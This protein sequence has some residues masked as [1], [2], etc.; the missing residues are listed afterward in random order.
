MLKFIKGLAMKIIIL[1]IA[2]ISSIF[3]SP[4]AEFDRQ[5]YEVGEKIFEKKCNSCHEKYMNIQLLMKNFLYEDNKLLNLK[6]PTGNELSF[7]LKNQIGSKD[8][9]EF[10]I[11]E[12]IDFVTDYLYE[13]DLS[14]TICLKGVIRHFKTMPSM[15][16]KISEEEIADVTFFLYFLEGFNNV[17]EFYYKDEF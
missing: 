17:N 9:I 13:P 3:A 14:K 1:T 15:K 12:D 10:Q 4:P 6:A 11:E 16:G 7:R 8:D 2:L 5:R